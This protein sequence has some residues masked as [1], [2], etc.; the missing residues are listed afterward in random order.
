MAGA[1]VDVFAVPD[2]LPKDGSTSSLPLIATTTTDVSGSVSNLALNA[3]ALNPRASTD[4]ARRTWWSLRQGTVGL[5]DAVGS[6][7]GRQKHERRH[8][9]SR[10]SDACSRHAR[11]IVAAGQRDHQ[12]HRSHPSLYQAGDFQ[13]GERSD[14]KFPLLPLEVVRAPD[15]DHGA[16]LRAGLRIWPVGGFA[17]ESTTYT[18]EADY[19]ALADAHRTIWA[20]YGFDRDQTRYCGRY[21]C[22]TDTSWVPSGWT[23]QLVG[24]DPDRDKQGRVIRVQKY[25][26]PAV[27]SNIHHEVILV[28][29]TGGEWH[30][31]RATN[32]V[33]ELGSQFAAAGFLTISAKVSFASGTSVSY[34]YKAGC[35]RRAR[36][37]F[38][39]TGS[40]R[41]TRRSSKPPA[42][43]TART[44]RESAAEDPGDD[45]SDRGDG[46][47]SRA[48]GL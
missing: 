5:V 6:G 44:I 10:R 35:T 17:K 24:S 28:R 29:R 11:S 26:V 13:R 33:A 30:W 37:I 42:R 43:T 14:I 9:S 23:G 2:S 27:D 36:V 21:G 15:S 3:T 18:A 25:T 19:G 8:T 46:M 32:Q 34:V 20:G 1:Q 45:C 31:S 40:T 38:G 39:V 48:L 12:R 41:T 4:S 47:R 7:D 22:S 16:D